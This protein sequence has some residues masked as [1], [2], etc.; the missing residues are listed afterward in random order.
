VGRV[1]DLCGRRRERAASPSERGPHL[2]RPARRSEVLWPN[3]ETRTIGKNEGVLLHTVRFIGSRQRARNHWWWCLSA[4]LRST[5]STVTAALTP[6]AAKCR[7]TRSR[8][9]RSGGAGKGGGRRERCDDR[10]LH[11]AAAN[12]S[13]RFHGSFSTARDHSRGNARRRQ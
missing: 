8:T 1:E 9:N 11:T 10:L 4:P 6:M 12:P 3:H 2:C 13:G 7:V 5:G